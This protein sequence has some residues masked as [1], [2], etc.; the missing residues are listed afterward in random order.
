MI[1]HGLSKIEDRNRF[2]SGNLLL[3][4]VFVIPLRDLVHRVHFKVEGSET[5][6]Y[7]TDLVLI[8]ACFKETEN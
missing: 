2:L 4:F 8:Y 5:L 6:N 3:C 7:G 1:V